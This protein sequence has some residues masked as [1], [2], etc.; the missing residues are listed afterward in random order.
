MEIAEQMTQHMRFTDEPIAKA[1]LEYD[2][3][4]LGRSYDAELLPSEEDGGCLVKFEYTSG[5][6]KRCSVTVAYSNFAD[7]EKALEKIKGDPRYFKNYIM[8]YLG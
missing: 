1:R 2:R 5:G 8:R 7:A 6:I 3:I 4:A